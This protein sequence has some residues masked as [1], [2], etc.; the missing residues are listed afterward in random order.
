M[1]KAVISILLLWTTAFSQSID[2][3]EFLLKNALDAIQTERG[4]IDVETRVTDEFVVTD[5]SDSGKGIDRRQ[6]K[7]V[8]RPG[9][10]TKKRGWGLGLSLARR[11]VEDYHGGSLVLLQSRPGDGST[12]RISLP[13]G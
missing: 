9:Y 7:N 4:T 8:F 3:R 10:S 6:W 12:F 2:T 5:V 1:G 13:K 11:I